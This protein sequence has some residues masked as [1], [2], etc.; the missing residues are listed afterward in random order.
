MRFIHLVFIS[1]ASTVHALVPHY[2][3][4]KKVSNKSFSPAFVAEANAVKV[5]EAMMMRRFSSAKV[6]EEAEA[7]EPVVVEEEVVEEAEA[8]EAIVTEDA[9]EGTG[10]LVAINTDTIQFSAGVVGGAVGFILGGPVL[11][12]IAA[13]LANYASK[14]EESVGQAVQTVSR[15]SIELYNSALEYDNENK[16]LEGVQAKL[17]EAIQKAKNDEN[18]DTIEQLEALY[19]GTSSKIEEVSKE[20]DLLGVSLTTLG[21]IGELFEKAAEKVI[22]LGDEYQIKDKASDLVKKIADSSKM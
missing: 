20:F 11:G 12:A 3:N 1:A 9:D 8:V 10:G 7:V 4:T 22:E 5:R 19:E 16:V 2:A 6:E 18:K 15:T 21:V 13:L 17:G 14:D